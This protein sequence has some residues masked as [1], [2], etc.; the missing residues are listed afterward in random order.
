MP[1][2]SVGLFVTLPI[3][4]IQQDSLSTHIAAYRSPAKITCMCS[5]AAHPGVIDLW[6]W[7]I[8][9]PAPAGLRNEDK[10]K[11]PQEKIETVRAI[12][13]GV[14]SGITLRTRI[15]KVEARVHSNDRIRV[16]DKPYN[17][18][19]PVGV[20]TDSADPYLGSSISCSVWD[21]LDSLLT[22]FTNTQVL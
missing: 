22:C 3:S 17:D 1:R 13:R 9:R 2:D 8:I 14:M 21:F 15:R 10:F 5:N 16:V 11:V 19:D 12:G 18:V 4:Y 7:Q 20:I 6:A